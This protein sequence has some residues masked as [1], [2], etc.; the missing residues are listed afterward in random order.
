M[1]GLACHEAGRDDVVAASLQG[2]LRQGF[3][4]RAIQDGAGGGG[5]DAAVAGAG[6]DVFFGA[7]K[8][9]A[10]VMGAE[11]AEGQVGFCRGAEQEARA[12]VGGI[13]ENFGAADGD[14]SGLGDYFHRIA[15]FVLLPVGC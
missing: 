10:G 4:W 7:V 9:G 2:Y 8:D 12:V 14:F 1:F 6:E 3:W 11:A 15:G 13:G 5:V